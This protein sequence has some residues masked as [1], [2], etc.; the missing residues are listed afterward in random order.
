M[1]AQHLNLCAK[2]G[3]KFSYIKN[4]DLLCSLKGNVMGISKGSQRDVRAFPTVEI[5]YNIN[6]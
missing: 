1:I 4:Y 6:K 3:R 5:T 2:I